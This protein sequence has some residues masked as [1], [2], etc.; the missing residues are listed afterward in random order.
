MFDILKTNPFVKEIRNKQKSI[1]DKQ[2][3]AMALSRRLQRA[4]K[5]SDSDVEAARWNDV[6]WNLGKY[7]IKVENRAYDPWVNIIT[8]YPEDEQ[9]SILSEG[10][11][12]KN[13][14][15]T[16]V[17]DRARPFAAPSARSRRNWRVKVAGVCPSNRVTASVK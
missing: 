1:E 5:L 2:N 15:T 14:G 4:M 16:S 17:I 9:I 10:W 6:S 12:V 3:E 11:F 8:I 13:S 7:C